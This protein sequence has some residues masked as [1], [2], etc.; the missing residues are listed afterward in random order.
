MLNNTDVSVPLYVRLDCGPS[1]RSDD[2]VIRPSKLGKDWRT[3]TM[4]LIMFSAS[5]MDLS[6]ALRFLIWPQWNKQAHYVQL[7]LDNIRLS[8]TYKL[9][10]PKDACPGTGEVSFTLVRKSNPTVQEQNAYQRINTAMTE[11]TQLYNCYTSLKRAVTVNYDP[12]VATANASH[13]SGIINF[14]GSISTRVALHEYG[15]IFG[16]GF[17]HFNSWIVEGKFTGPRVSALIKKIEN[18]PAAFINGGGTHIWP[19]GLNFD[20]EDGNQERIHHCLIVEALASDIKKRGPT[21]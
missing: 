10:T 13:S 2:F 9:P 8:Q 6:K 5:G 15:H 7:Q 19:H 18:N 14:G 16:V 11:A 3:F 4:P 20:R 1:C 21:Q 17:G 12:A